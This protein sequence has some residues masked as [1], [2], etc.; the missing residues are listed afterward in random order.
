[1]GESP[2]SLEKSGNAFTCSS[3]LG[4]LRLRCRK[5]PGTVCHKDRG[6]RGHPE[7]SGVRAVGRSPLRVLGGVSRAPS[8]DLRLRESFSSRVP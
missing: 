7:R 1:M 4:N 8:T 5:S 2:E 6:F 3:R